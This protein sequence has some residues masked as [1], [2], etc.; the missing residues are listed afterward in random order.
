MA[1]D[2]TTALALVRRIRLGQRLRMLREDCRF[3]CSVA[4]PG[5]WEILYPQSWWSA[6]PSY[7]SLFFRGTP[8]ETLDSEPVDAGVTVSYLCRTSDICYVPSEREL[9]GPCRLCYAFFDGPATH[10]G[11]QYPTQLVTI[12]PALMPLLL[13]TPGLARDTSAAYTHLRSC[14]KYFHKSGKGINKSLRQLREL[15]RILRVKSEPSLLKI[16]LI[17]HHPHSH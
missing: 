15:R 14:H 16:C 11:L 10:K 17:S 4:H 6:S 12:L 13:L 7:V 9:D 5:R 8:S 2:I 1:K 3:A